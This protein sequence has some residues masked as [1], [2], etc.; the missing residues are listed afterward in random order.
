MTSQAKPSDPKR[1]L[2]YQ[3]LRSYAKIKHKVTNN[4]PKSDSKVSPK[5]FFYAQC[6]PRITPNSLSYAHKLP[7]DSSES[8]SEIIPKYH[9]MY[10]QYV[11]NTLQ[12]GPKSSFALK[13]NTSNVDISVSKKLAINTKHDK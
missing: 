7:P 6:S 3:K 2:K 10:V 12:S 11:L 8:D 13:A 9:P 5:P 4:W 1:I